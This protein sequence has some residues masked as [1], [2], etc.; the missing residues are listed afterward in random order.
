MD[1]NFF[2][3][4]GVKRSIKFKLF[5]LQLRIGC[6]PFFLQYGSLYSLYSLVMGLQAGIHTGRK[7]DSGIEVVKR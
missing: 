6:I 3:F 1:L 7:L 2:C 5:L 4:I